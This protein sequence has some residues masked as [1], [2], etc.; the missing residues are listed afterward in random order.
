[1][2]WKY[3]IQVRAFSK[4]FINGSDH[5]RYCWLICLKDSHKC[6]ES[7]PLLF[8]YVYWTDVEHGHIKPTQNYPK[9]GENQEH[10]RQKT[11]S[12]GSS[13]RAREPTAI[14]AVTSHRVAMEIIAMS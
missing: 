10:L 14:A 13:S 8:E 5:I 6:T 2:A 11:S 4:L 1:M 9:K 7:Y 3:Y 12:L